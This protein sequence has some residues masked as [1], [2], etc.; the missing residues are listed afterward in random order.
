MDRDIARIYGELYLRSVNSG[1]KLSQ[2]D[3]MLAAMAKQKK[4]VLLTADNDFKALPE[5]RTENWLTQL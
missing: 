5:I 4:L 1:R 3:L 2:V